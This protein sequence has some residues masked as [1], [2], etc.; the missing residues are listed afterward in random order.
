[1]LPESVTKFIGQSGKIRIMEVERGAIKKFADA[2]DDRNPLYWDE[3]YARD[4]R[5]GSIIAMPG[6]FGWVTTW[7]GAMP[8]LDKFREGA[9][10]ALSDAGYGRSLDGGM[11]Y[12][13]FYPVRVGDT[14]ASLEMITDIVERQ[15]K[16][17]KMVFMFTETAYTNQNGELVA[18]ARQT[19]IHR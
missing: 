16:T 18:K 13:F 9:R 17:G 7:T 19:N 4:S 6:F 3:E 2:I 14:L 10:A 5:Y 8:G 12:E 11:E 15:G 1:M